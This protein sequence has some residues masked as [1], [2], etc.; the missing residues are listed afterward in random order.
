MMALAGT[1]VRTKTHPSGRDDL[2][3]I[4]P[5]SNLPLASLLRCGNYLKARVFGDCGNK[6]ETMS[7]SNGDR[8]HT[9]SASI[10]RQ[11]GTEANVR[12]LRS[13]PAF[14]VDLELPADLREILNKMERNEA[15]AAKRER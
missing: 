2:I 3:Q 1:A 11:I 5:C 15:R 6:V 8:S 12:Y 10:R 9:L 7:R 4:L 13:L 14:R